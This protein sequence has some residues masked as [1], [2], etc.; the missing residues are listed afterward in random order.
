MS[1]IAIMNSHKW[2]SS[3]IGRQRQ[4]YDSCITTLKKL[5]DEKE[6]PEVLSSSTKTKESVPMD[7]FGYGSIGYLKNKFLPGNPP[8]EEKVELLMHE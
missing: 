2:Y 7:N 3:S 1:P 6:G 8:D 4:Y 5:I